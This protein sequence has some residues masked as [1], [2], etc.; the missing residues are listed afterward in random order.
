MGLRDRP[1]A[2]AGRRRSFQKWL[3]I[4][5]QEQHHGQQDTSC[6]SAKHDGKNKVSSMTVLSIMGKTGHQA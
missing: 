6:D 3:D 2:V 5:P 4:L 1:A